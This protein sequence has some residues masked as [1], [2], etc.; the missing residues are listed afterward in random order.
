MLHYCHLPHKRKRD[1]D[2]LMKQHEIEIKVWHFAKGFMSFKE[3]RAAAVEKLK[4]LSNA[5]LDTP[6]VVMQRA[7]MQYII[8]SPLERDLYLYHRDSREAGKRLRSENLYAL[9]RKEAEE[10]FT[11]KSYND[12]RIIAREWLRANRH[13]QGRYKDGYKQYIND[14]RWCPEKK[15]IACLESKDRMYRKYEEK[16]HKIFNGTPKANWAQMANVLLDLNTSIRTMDATAC[17]AVIKEITGISRHGGPR[18]K[19]SEKT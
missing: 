3:A 14:Q 19:M 16:Y 1:I 11:G 9:G 17:R 10:F 2:K 12:S 5:P 7:V 4:N 15:D 13:A 18:A 8:N 6:A